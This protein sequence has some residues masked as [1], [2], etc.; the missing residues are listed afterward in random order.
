MRR[1]GPY[2][3]LRTLGRGGMGE[4]FEV[5]HEGTGARYALKTLLAL[6][7]ETARARF[8]RELAALGRLRHEALVVVHAAEAE[9]PTPYVVTDLLPGG[10]LQARLDRLQGFTPEVALEL[11][12]RVAAGV[13]AAHGL[14]VLHRDL[15]PDN[16]LFDDR[17]LPRLVDFGLAR[18]DDAR[19]LTESGAVIGSP[20][21]LAPE[22]ALG[23]GGV[24]ERTD[25]Y[26]LGA[27]LFACLTGR[28]PFAQH[29]SLLQHLDRVASEAP[30]APSRFVGDVPGWL[31]RVV[32]RALAKDPQR[33][34]PSVSALRAALAAGP[35]GAPGLGRRAGLGVLALG[36]GLAIWVAGRQVPAAA[37]RG[38]G[39]P[40][41]SAPQVSGAP[42]RERLAAEAALAL[43]EDRP[44]AALA[45]VRS[46]QALGGPLSRRWRE[47]EDAARAL[48]GEGGERRAEVAR[49]AGEAARLQ[50]RV[51]QVERD[52]LPLLSGQQVIEFRNEL[53]QL[54]EA[55]GRRDPAGLGTPALLRRA[56]RALATYLVLLPTHFT[57][58]GLD[59]FRRA[60]SA[61]PL[62]P[63]LRVG[64]AAYQQLRPEQWPTPTLERVPA[65]LDET[66]RALAEALLL[67]ARWGPLSEQELARRAE[68]GELPRA[69]SFV[70]AEGGPVARNVFRRLHGLL[71]RAERSAFYAFADSHPAAP[72]RE[73]Y[74][75]WGRV[76]RQR[77]ASCFSYYG[78]QPDHEG[79]RAWAEWL[80]LG[81]AAEEA[82]RELEHLSL[83]DS[84]ERALFKA[85]VDLGLGRRRF[86]N[87][88]IRRLRSVTRGSKLW[89]VANSQLAAVQWSLN[90]RSW[91]GTL[92]GAERAAEQD[93]RPASL[94][95]PWRLPVE[96]RQ[97]LEGGGLR[98]RLQAELS[99]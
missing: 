4:V 23:V 90:E 25:V 64:L 28:P 69:P 84:F 21:Y 17:D 56:D 26:G 39:A 59:R 65:G 66:W 8:T 96:T 79:I 78:S 45:A 1:W 80:L 54:L 77:Y 51:S 67:L 38:P 97:E 14:G 72:L 93:F 12:D 18:L 81:G 91:R 83:D 33:R 74:L 15:K 46:A 61:R 29:G 22:Q 70:R 50:R 30:P 76:A 95:L 3:A 41:G 36:C 16:V 99:R 7:D 68:A 35:S 53:V 32:L 71:A 55:V 44:G 20:G 2:R 31:D 85:E 13:E 6:G 86:A 57:L 34:Y 94:C 5:V 89:L 88:L 63:E 9:G 73:R 82:A 43:R 62:G 92:R 48:S 98:R 47:L 27:L 10:S 24:D 52:H 40:P 49:L 37:G 75:R 42:S 58:D 60:V 11:V 19:S 87:D